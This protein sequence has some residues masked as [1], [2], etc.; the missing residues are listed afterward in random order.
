MKVFSSQSLQEPWTS[1][2]CQL[3]VSSAPRKFWQ[4]LFDSREPP[5]PL[6][7][8]H[9][10]RRHACV[11]IALPRRWCRVRFDPWPS[12]KW[13]RASAGSLAVFT[14]AVGTASFLL[15][16]SDVSLCS[17]AP[18]GESL[19]LLLIK[20]LPPF[21]EIIRVILIKIGRFIQSLLKI[22]NNFPEKKCWIITFR[23]TW[24]SRFYNFL[25]E[26]PTTRQSCQ[27]ILF[28]TSCCDGSF[29][30]PQRNLYHWPT[31][32]PIRPCLMWP[33]CCESQSQTDL[34]CVSRHTNSVT[35]WSRLE[36]K[37]SSAGRVCEEQLS[38]RS[39]KA[40]LGAVLSRVNDPE[41]ATF[42]QSSSQR[43]ATGSRTVR[44]SDACGENDELCHTVITFCVLV[45]S[46]ASK[47]CKN[48]WV[49]RSA[50]FISTG[51]YL[52]RSTANWNTSNALLILDILL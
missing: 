52:V 46:E 22:Y 31:K 15:T 37:N 29:C 8:H 49:C 41:E 18:F 13:P 48:F 1:S 32:T 30:R 25:T 28:A 34:S 2:P 45:T 36:T 10:P 17:P 3:D 44:F 50:V 12:A 16:R 51:L 40:D 19:S 39:K 14:A 9:R 27:T 21:W 43:R 24:F 20:S 42:V 5:R 26:P 23:Y 4:Q 35:Q 11:S 38:V 6:H 7:H 33:C 47:S